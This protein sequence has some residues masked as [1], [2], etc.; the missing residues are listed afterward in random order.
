M[1]IWHT[2]Q[3]TLENVLV[4]PLLGQMDNIECAKDLYEIYYITISDLRKKAAYWIFFNEIEEIGIL[5]TNI[6]HRLG[7]LQS[8]AKLKKRTRSFMRR[9]TNIYD[10]VKYTYDRLA[11]RKKKWKFISGHN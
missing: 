4:A 1:S 11:I 2:I 8:F 7:Y 6:R 5:K 10:K 3:N 9:W